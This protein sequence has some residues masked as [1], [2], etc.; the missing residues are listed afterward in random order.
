METKQNKKI[1]RIKIKKIT[2]RPNEDVYD[3]SVKNNHNFFANNILI[4]NCFEI[5]FI[6]VTDDGRCG[7]QMCNLTS[8]NGAKI[9][10]S[11]K[12]K[13]ATWAA[14][15]IGTLQAGYTSFPYLG[16]TS[17]EL[18]NNE[19]LLGVSITGMMDNPDILFN[20]EFQKQSAKVAVETNKIW[21]KK[22]GINQAARITC[23]KPEGCVV[24]E[25]IIKTSIGDKTL[26]ELFEINGYKLEDYENLNEKQFL[27][28]TSKIMVKDEN[29]DWQYITKLYINGVSDTIDVEMDDGTI[30]TT[31]PNHKFL[32]KGRGYVEA[33][34]LEKNDDILSFD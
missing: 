3:I 23:I 9:T 5:S 20:P 27:P 21:A 19:A 1:T 14:T 33:R 17:E 29:N 15:L 4:H 6:P 10:S 13:D 16:H 31:T 12:F 24:P 32:V 2:V 18:S 11:D 26:S 22:I 28:V 8:I 7:F 25:T 34:N 30:V